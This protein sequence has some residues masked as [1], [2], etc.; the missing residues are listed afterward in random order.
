MM[1]PCRIYSF[2]EYKDNTQ[3]ADRLQQLINDID[4]LQT[5][6]TNYDTQMDGAEA[7][8]RPLL[9]QMGGTQGIK[10]FDDLRAKVSGELPE[11]Q[12]TL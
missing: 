10:T 9:A 5:Q 12:R 8:M 4:S 11:P 3:R 6:V 7:A 2:M 1:L